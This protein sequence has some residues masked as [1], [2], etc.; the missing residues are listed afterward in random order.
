MKNV[1]YFF[2]LTM[3][4]FVTSCNRDEVVKK[5][6]T[7]LEKVQQ[8]YEKWEE[9]SL[10]IHVNITPG[11][12]E[13]VIRSHPQLLQ[14]LE[15]HGIDVNKAFSRNQT[16]ERTPQY[17]C[18][19]YYFPCDFI[20]DLGDVNDDLIYDDDDIDAIRDVILGVTTIPI[21]ISMG[22]GTIDDARY[23]SCVAVCSNGD[24]PCE[25]LNTIDLL[26]MDYFVNSLVI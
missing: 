26:A 4:V 5:S 18:S 1:I 16:V 12:V 23:L 17:Y 13:Q 11:Y 9:P 2:L 10:P 6:L 24:V 20:F 19:G 22:N 21:S 15:M 14:D 25:N 3:G 8:L 7:N